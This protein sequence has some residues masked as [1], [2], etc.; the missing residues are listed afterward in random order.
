VASSILHPGWPE[1]RPWQALSNEIPG[2]DDIDYEGKI[3]YAT[4][5]LL[6]ELIFPYE[7]E[8]PI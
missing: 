4:F 2:I 5:H 8:D 3:D 6:T 1:K 7:P